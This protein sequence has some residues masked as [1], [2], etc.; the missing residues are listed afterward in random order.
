MNLE[1]CITYAAPP[2]STVADLEPLASSLLSQIDRWSVDTCVD[3]DDDSLDDTLILFTELNT[4][5][6][7]LGAET[8]CSLVLPDS[9]SGLD[10]RVPVCTSLEDCVGTISA[11]TVSNYVI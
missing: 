8:E 5:L 4:V 7:S 10:I 1:E 11:E 9:E 3:T 2:G 6:W